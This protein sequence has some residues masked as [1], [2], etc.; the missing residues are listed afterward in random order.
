MSARD[1]AAAFDGT[2]ETALMDPLRAR[3]THAMARDTILGIGLFVAAWIVF[4]DCECTAEGQIIGAAEDPA[5]SLGH[6][7]LREGFDDGA[8][9][10]M[11][12]VYEENA[13]H[14]WVTET[15]G[16]LEFHSTVEAAGAFAGYVADTWRLDPTD[17]FEMKVDL[18]YSPVT[19]EGGWMHFGLTP[20]AAEPR[21]QYVTIGIGCVNRHSHF[22][23]EKRDGLSLESG[24]VTRVRDGVT[25]Y[26]S[27]DASRDELY[28][29]D[30]GYGEENAWMTVPGLLKGQWGGR[31]LFIVVGGTAE[32]LA[33]DTGQAFA[34]NLLVESGRVIE[35]SL[36][37]VYRFFAPETG[38]YFY[39]ISKQEKEKLLTE[40]REVWQ[41]EGAVFRSFPDDSDPACRPVYRFWSVQLGTHFYT[42]QEHERD[43]LIESYA[44]SWAYE[45]VAFYAYPEDQQPPWALPV[46]RFWSESI[47]GHFYTMSEAEKDDLLMER[48]GVWKYEGIAWY[49]V[50]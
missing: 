24:V 44:D 43:K 15:N 19:Y 10:S 32:H 22:L 50:E 35:A 45:G 49:A 23:Y 8:K 28:L 12:T 48:A 21:S 6:L 38:R 16:R 36:Q 39:T 33:I 11:W 29:G 31:M 20:D 9:H 14:C 13:E 3:G 40:Y 47:R 26:L 18:H 5:L 2:G 41:Y 4:A 7:I 25:L 37:P 30:G 46:Y 42:M 17:D 1:A 34:D 27:Y